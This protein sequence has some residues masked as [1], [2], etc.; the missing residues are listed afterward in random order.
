M[1]RALK[2]KE[3]YGTVTIDNLSPQASESWPEAINVTLSF[4]EALKLQLGLQ[5][6][7]MDINRLNRNTRDGRRA[8]VNICVWPKG[9]G[10]ITINR[11]RTR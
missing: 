10:K 11:G 2:T 9:V 1:A 6:A 5:H 7:L 3:S 8:G 4:E